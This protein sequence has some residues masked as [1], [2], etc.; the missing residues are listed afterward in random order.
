MKIDKKSLIDHYT[1]I[2][3]LQLVIDGRNR[4]LIDLCEF[5]G[6]GTTWIKYKLYNIQD[7]LIIA[8]KTTI[9]WLFWLG[10]YLE[11]IK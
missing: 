4:T 3:H 10:C 11:I 8:Y 5:P 2:S 6:F 1:D 7:K 9:L